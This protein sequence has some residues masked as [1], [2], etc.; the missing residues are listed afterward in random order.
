MP[1]TGNSKGVFKSEEKNQMEPLR[2]PRGVG[3][4]KK[5]A[6]GKGRKNPT[7]PLLLKNYAVS[8]IERGGGERGVRRPRIRGPGGKNGRGPAIRA[9]KT[10]KWK[11]KFVRA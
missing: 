7:T 2:G 3:K 4:Q 8:Y 11:K 10:C 9:K 6:T 5:S 1:Q